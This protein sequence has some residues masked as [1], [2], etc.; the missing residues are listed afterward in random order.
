MYVARRTSGAQVI[1]G[2]IKER[3]ELRNQEIGLK[4]DVGSKRWYCN[5]ILENVLH[6]R[7]VGVRFGRRTGW[8]VTEGDDE[9][10]V[11]SEVESVKCHFAVLVVFG[12]SREMAWMERGIVGIVLASPAIVLVVVREAG[13]TQLIEAKNPVEEKIK[14]RNSNVVLGLPLRAL[15]LE[16]M[17]VE[18][19]SL[20]EVVGI[21]QL[22]EKRIGRV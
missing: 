8:M 20:V 15:C 12:V 19:G 2:K 16:V 9:I 11:E 14:E 6:S 5:L 1:P 18:A 21:H 4:L 3:D 13:R 7:S 22:L 17:E 10:L